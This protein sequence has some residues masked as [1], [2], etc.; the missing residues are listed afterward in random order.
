MYIFFSKIRTCWRSINEIT[1]SLLGEHSIICPVW[2]LLLFS[3]S[4]DHT[5]AAPEIPRLLSSWKLVPVNSGWHALGC[6]RMCRI[7]LG[8]FRLTWS[9]ELQPARSLV[10]IHPRW[11]C[12][13][14]WNW[15]FFKA[16]ICKT[17]FPCSLPNSPKL[18]IENYFVL[19]NC[20]SIVREHRSSIRWDLRYS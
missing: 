3:V 13:S 18:N 11:F 15:N 10:Q 19:C 1:L 8:K 2:F 9:L 12:D 6:H 7:L 4:A 14:S 17:I 16:L 20:P 5:M